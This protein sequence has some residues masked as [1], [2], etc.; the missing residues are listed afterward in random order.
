MIKLNR[1]LF[2]IELDDSVPYWKT[3]EEQLRS[4][5]FDSDVYEDSDENFCIL[6]FDD[7]RS[8]FDSWTPAERAEYLGDCDTPNYTVYDWIR[9]CMM[10]SLSIV[11]SIS[12][13]K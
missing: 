4:S 5:L 8:D 6:T 3:T 10:N 1:N 12:A 7:I 9:D 2:D 13:K 11:K